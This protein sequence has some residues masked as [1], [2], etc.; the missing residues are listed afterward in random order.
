MPLEEMYSVA[1]PLCIDR[2]IERQI[3]RDDRQ[4]EEYIVWMEE[5]IKNMLVSDQGK[6]EKGRSFVSISQSHNQPG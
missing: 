1:P 5:T 4:I 3:Q 2:L 6:I